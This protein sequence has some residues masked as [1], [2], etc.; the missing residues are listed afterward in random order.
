M[1]LGTLAT[2]YPNGS[3]F[4]FILD[5]QCP[6]Q[7]RPGRLRYYYVL[8]DSSSSVDAFAFMCHSLCEPQNDRLMK[9]WYQLFVRVFG[10]TTFS[11]F[12]DTVHNTPIQDR[13]QVND[14]SMMENAKGRL[15]ALFLDEASARLALETYNRKQDKVFAKKQLEL[16]ARQQNSS[17]PEKGQN[18]KPAKRLLTSHRTSS[19]SDPSLARNKQCDGTSV[20]PHHEHHRVNVQPPTLS[21]MAAST[22]LVS[23]H[24][25]HNGV[26]QWEESIVNKAPALSRSES[27][28]IKKTSSPP[29]WTDLLH[30]LQANEQKEAQKL[31][32]DVARLR[33]LLESERRSRHNSINSHREIVSPRVPGDGK[34]R[35]NGVR[36]LNAQL[37]EV[38]ALYAAERDAHSLDADRWQREEERLQEKIRKL[39]HVHGEKLSVILKENQR[40]V[41]RL[42]QKFREKME[43][44]EQTFNETLQGRD[45]RLAQLSE[46]LV[47]AEISA[48]QCTLEAQLHRRNLE[49][50]EVRRTSPSQKNLQDQNFMLQQEVLGAREEIKRLAYQQSPYTSEVANL[51]QHLNLLQSQLMQ[52]T[53]EKKDLETAFLRS[54][55]TISQ[56]QIELRHAE[57]L[58]NALRD[59]L[60]TVQSELPNL[61]MELQSKSLRTT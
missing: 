54:Q 55:H 29:G 53:K 14:T 3:I 7:P 58:I 48:R 20:S 33:Q 52:L 22:E 60:Q 43:S 51:A 32:Q 8:S 15:P 6:N 30:Q 19:S 10:S 45:I 39:S 28:K 38:T 46:D 59:G 17:T 24:Q 9:Q 47:K 23:S 25:Q 35:I 49:E 40:T 31:H 21:N 12:M 13:T 56:Q 18:S 44:M 2:P 34:S 16:S 61:R 41:D 27:R 37:Q 50:A 36:S 4:Y 26:V 11:D 5:E 57:G 1:E 42:E